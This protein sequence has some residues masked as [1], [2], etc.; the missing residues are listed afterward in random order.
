MRG[1]DCKYS[2]E[3]YSLIDGLQSKYSIDNIGDESDDFVQRIN[4][5][6]NECNR[7][8][9]DYGGDR[10]DRITRYFISS[11]SELLNEKRVK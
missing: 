10:K 7:E 9:N 1:E 6:I 5:F 3:M 11:I 4:G 8:I 2:D